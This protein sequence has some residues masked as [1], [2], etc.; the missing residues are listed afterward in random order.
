MPLTASQSV[1][2]VSELGI[3]KINP[4]L[5]SDVDLWKLREELINLECDEDLDDE[6]RDIAAGLVDYMSSIISE[7]WSRKTPSE[8]EAMLR[9]TQETALLQRVAAV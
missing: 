8:V 7:D 1:F 3:D 9:E 2:L 4:T 6:K 5:M